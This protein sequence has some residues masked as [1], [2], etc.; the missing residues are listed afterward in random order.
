M[1]AGLLLCVF[2]AAVVSAS[3]PRAL[4]T[5]RFDV[6]GG[7]NGLEDDLRAASLVV[8][9][10][11]EDV[12]DPQELIAAARAD[13]GRL[14]GALYS[15][16]HFGG[17]VN[18]LIDGVE[19]AQIPPLARLDAIGTIEV[20]VRPGPVYTLSEARIAPLAPGTE[21]PDGFAVGEPARSPV[22]RDAAESAVS[23]WRAVGNAKADVGAQDV[24][25][26]HGQDAL[27][28]RITM[29]PGPVVTFGNLIL[30]GGDSVRPERL[31]A[32]AGL[33]VGETF[34]PDALDDAER[35]LRETGVFSS[36]A[37]REAETLGP[38]NSM[39]ITA[40][41]AENR[42]RRIG[43]GAEFSTVDG[44]GLT[45]FWLHRNLLG[46]A[47]RLR[48]D[49]E[50]GGIG[51]GTGGIDYRLASRLERPSTFRADTD[52]FLEA[53]I[54]RE[55]EPE[56]VSDSFTI[57]AG[58]S[59]RIND[60]LTVEGGL[61]YRLSRDEDDTGETTY[62]LLTLPL[63]ALYDSRDE[64]LNATEGF[65]VDLGLTPFLGLNDESGTGGRL[66]F[67]ARTY[68]GLGAEDRVVLA[69]RLQGGSILGTDLREVPNDFRFYSGGGGTVRGQE[70][71]SLGVMLDDDVDSGGASFVGVQAEVRGR[72]TDNIGLVGFADYGIVGE[73][74]FPGSDAEDHAGAGIGIRYNTPIGPI[75]L[76]V[77][78]PV[79]G[80]DDDGGVE[81]YIG[82]GQAF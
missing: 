9:A 68:L 22:I 70:Y 27:A 32:I 71:Q 58:L 30:R 79:S 40:Q 69:A 53:E 55:D 82:I 78:A 37:L 13:Y 7:E 66:T 6:D 61:G 38:D 34:S 2:G 64:P 49:A 57:A 4:D 10:E 42:P 45:A 54:A 72:I 56:F 46:G 35:R 8:A 20:R 52:A 16:G 44:L 11:A 19:A 48:F 76:D 26:Q 18:I 74:S 47:E 67:D 31:R 62:S 50:V 3:A 75:R 77:A 41:L 21:L 39:D 36:V 1:R 29:A 80:D 23:G 25:A 65:Y 63:E 33:P 60:E 14:V 81:I 51:G 59:R 73:D 5:L 15:E 24:V 17:I 43:F 12:D 28:A